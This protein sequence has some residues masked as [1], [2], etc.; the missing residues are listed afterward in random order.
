MS[1]SAPKMLL[2]PVLESSNSRQSFPRKWGNTYN[3]YNGHQRK[4]Q[5]SNL[6]STQ[7][8]YVKAASLRR[9]RCWCVT[10]C[11][12]AKE[13][14]KQLE[15]I[16]P[17]IFEITIFRNV[18]GITWV[19][20]ITY[21]QSRRYIRWKNGMQWRALVLPTHN[22]MIIDGYRRVARRWADGSSAGS[23]KLGLYL[24]MSAETGN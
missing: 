5:P 19:C 9:M 18:Q 16:N 14:I 20:N 10:E 15:A 6:T 24:D 17:R 13:K 12:W 22:G 8:V 11:R 2:F 3:C 7:T 23:K 4:V 1:E 21:C